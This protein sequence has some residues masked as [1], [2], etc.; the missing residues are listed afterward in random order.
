M[1]DSA[2]AN[3]N[4]IRVLYD[5]GDATILMKNQERTCL[6]HWIQ[7]LEKHTKVDICIDLQDQHRQLCR[8][9]KNATSLSES[10][11]YYLAIRAW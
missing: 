4:A 9:Y 6:F 11:T 5:S 2:Q 10:Q 8:K 1:A 3:W 7:S